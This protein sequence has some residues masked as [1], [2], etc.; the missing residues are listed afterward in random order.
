M[1][2][3]RMLAGTGRGRMIDDG[4]SARP[5]QASDGQATRRGSAGPAGYDANLTSFVG[6][7]DLISEA[8]ALLADARLL[9]L[10]GFG[11]VGK[12]RLLLRL[13]TV[14]AATD[15]YPDGI[16]VVQLLDVSAQDDDLVAA[17]CADQL[18]ILDNADGPP[19]DRLTEFLAPRRALLML[20]NCE[21][22]VGDEP[23]SGPV[24]RLLATLLRKAPYLTVVATSRARVGVS[25]EH[26]LRI[27]PLPPDDALRLLRDRAQAAGTPIA[28]EELP[29]A[30]RL[31]EITDGLPRAIEL[32]AVNLEVVATLQE[33]VADPTL[34]RR[35]PG[36]SEQQNH[37]TMD[38]VIQ[39]SFDQLGERQQRTLEL[40]SVFEGG[41][42]LEA[43]TAVCTDNGINKSDVHGLL[44][45]LNEK[46]LL[47]IEPTRGRTRYRMPELY[48]QFAWQIIAAAGEEAGIRDAHASHFLD[49]AAR[50]STQWFSPD[51]AD[52]MHRLRTELPN[53]R[54]AQEHLLSSPQTAA[55]GLTLAVN[56]TA[57]RATVFAGVLNEARRMLNRGLSHQ[58]T[59]P[60]LGHVAALAQIAWIAQIQGSD[61]A[62]PAQ[63]KAEQAG[64][65]LG[66]ADSFGALL[67]SRG[68]R[69]WLA[70][71]DPRRARE[72]IAVFARAEQAF[73][74]S[75]SSGHRW[76][77]PAL[78]GGMATVF[79]GDPEEAF[80][81]SSRV[82][83]VAE[84][85]EAPWCISWAQWTSGL[86]ELLHRDAREAARRAQHAL[87]TQLSIGDRWG[88]PWSLWQLALAALR[89]GDGERGARLLGGAGVAQQLTQTN[90]LG[91]VPFLHVQERI[92][93]AARERFRDT[94][95]EHVKSGESLA[96]SMDTVYALAQEPFDLSRPLPVKT[97]RAS[98]L[99]EREQEV[100]DL[101]AEAHDD[102]TIGEALSISPR[103]VQK[104]VQNILLKMGL[105]K[106]EQI[107]VMML[108][109]VPRVDR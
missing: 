2:N 32:V 103:T 20:D 78:Y 33:M 64:R 77:M 67:Y 88:P 28:E 21:H 94:F 22:L 98:V 9:T 34:I 106:R 59:S 65:E 97:H 71:R 44:T 75:H 49:L 31:Y 60:S 58:P 70:E 11:G 92:V 87:Q 41:F 8:T 66:C 4:N 35:L 46:S 109:A 27:H 52:W 6:R 18:G 53:F 26:V 48:R 85:A 29:L 57:S 63:A 47:L 62:G 79:Y 82:L 80:A 90:V 84:D 81:A 37:R 7:T 74:E 43:A 23:G 89:L 96:R 13:A 10:F 72:S 30:A 14:L 12:T 100:A 1:L 40:V 108:R 104:H 54:A 17:A 91:L 19:L 69:L 86:A 39:W 51:E 93:S 36:P 50:G 95:D 55:D 45:F 83:E 56:I 99:T 101:V 5:A 42:D 107:I 15:D 73:R 3:R 102:K 24:A 68:T 25:G 105:K 76:F 16:W 61:A 38:A